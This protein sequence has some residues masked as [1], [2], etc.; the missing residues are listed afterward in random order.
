MLLLGIFGLAIDL[1]AGGLGPWTFIGARV[2]RRGIDLAVRRF[3]ARSIPSW[4][5]L[6]LVCGGTVLFMLSG[7]T[8]MIRS[9]FS[10]PTIGREELIGEMGVAEVDVEP[11]GVVRVRDA[12][13]RARTNRATPI[14]AGDEIRVVA[15]EGVVL[16]VDRPKAAREITE[17]APAARNSANSCRFWAARLSP[18]GGPDTFRRHRPGRGGTDMVALGIIH[19]T[20]H[21]KAA[22]RGPESALFFPPTLA[23]AAR[24]ARSRAKRARRRSAR[25]ATCATTASTSRS[26][27]AN[28]TAS[29]AASP[30][31]NVA[32]ASRAT[33]PRTY[34]RGATR[35]PGIRSSPRRRVTPSASK[36]VSSGTTYLRLEPKRSRTSETVSAPRSTTARATRSLASS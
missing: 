23:R 32:A 3:V 7:M 21:L 13:W 6:V 5:V 20:W 25:S 30:R 35:A 14:T 19:E 17:S 34:G 10:T 22:C 2:A 29:G 24:R 4:W 18:S 27:C 11:D 1:Q 26:V 15:V 31:P 33:E 12:L 36:R 9:R 16:E 28:R 8:A